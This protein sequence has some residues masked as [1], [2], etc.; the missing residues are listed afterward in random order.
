[1]SSFALLAGGAGV[2]SVLLYVSLLTGTIAAYIL[3]YLAQLPLFLIGLWVGTGGVLIAGLTATVIAAT[4]GGLMFATTYLIANAMP[5]LF[6][7]RQALLSRG[8]GRGGIEWYPSGLL[9]A[10]LAGLVAAAF[11]TLTLA[12]TPISGGFEGM[13][14][15]LIERG[16]REL[17]RYDPTGMPI[18][19]AAYMIVQFFP[20]VVAAS[21]LVMVA[22]NGSLAQGL[23]VR[24]GR[25]RR[26]SP[27]LA[28]LELPGWLPGAAAICGIGAMMPGL[29]GFVGRN[30]IL[31][32]GATFAFAG[33]AVIHAFARRW[34]NRLLWLT[35]VYVFIFLFGWPLLFVALLGAIEPWANLRKRFSGGPPQS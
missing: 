22:I 14:R 26:P 1:M 25:N 6:M 24:F 29:A 7:T 8:D 31:I 32:I 13:L 19:H 21:W 18:E 3:A 16:L 5:V 33:L 34:G 4:F 27:D 11:V 20:G 15:Q 35:A 12:L 30:L 10:W 23:L 17:G 2:A 9:V 28:A